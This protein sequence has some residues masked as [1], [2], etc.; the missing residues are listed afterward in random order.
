MCCLGLMYEIEHAA[1]DEALNVAQHCFYK[2]AV[3]AGTV[4]QANI[5]PVFYPGLRFTNR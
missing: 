3:P 1:P 5:N 2:H 4:Q